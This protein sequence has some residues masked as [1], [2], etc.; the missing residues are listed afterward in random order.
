MALSTTGIL[1]GS[2]YWLNNVVIKKILEDTFIWRT[3]Y[4]YFYV[5]DV[6]VLFWDFSLGRYLVR[7]LSLE[8][9]QL[10]WYLL[11]THYVT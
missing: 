2:D 5:Q 8:Q 11:G 10:K 1:K 4:Y 6:K 9:Y 7:E 3:I